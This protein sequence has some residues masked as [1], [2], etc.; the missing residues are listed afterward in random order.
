MSKTDEELEKARAQ[1]REGF[2]KQYDGS[3]TTGLKKQAV[4]E[5]FVYKVLEGTELL[6]NIGDWLDRW[7]P[8][9][10]IPLYDFLGFTEQEWLMIVEDNRALGFIVQERA[11]R[12]GKIKVNPFD[13]QQ[14][15]DQIA[16]REA[17][18]WVMVKSAMDPVEVLGRLV[19][20][21]VMDRMP[22]CLMVRYKAY[23]FMNHKLFIDLNDM[24]NIQF[25][26]DLLNAPKIEHIEVKV[27]IE[28]IGKTAVLPPVT[29]EIIKD[30]S[31]SIDGDDIDRA[32][33][34]IDGLNKNKDTDG[35]KVFP[36]KTDKV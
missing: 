21:G 33:R 9:S 23:G 22:A 35:P 14:I 36:E 30:F 15:L 2:S 13:Y 1:I 5:S 6:T 8:E 3:K 34:I 10:L 24:A 17:S 18:M 25:H 31:Q 27:H 7:T 26:W 4:R 29:P 16:P 12:L 32:L 20:Q 19:R 28:D 11:F